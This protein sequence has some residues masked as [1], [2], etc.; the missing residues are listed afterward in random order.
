LAIDKQYEPATPIDGLVEMEPEEGLDIEI[1]NALTTETEDGG[2]I[3]DFDPSA[4]EMQAESFDSNLVEYLDDDELNSIGNEL[5]N[6][7]NS[8]RDSRADWEETYTKV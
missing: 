2:M 3:V 8:D 4:N 7:F 1:Q 6:A 5:L